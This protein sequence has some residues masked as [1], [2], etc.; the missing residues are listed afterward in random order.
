MKKGFTLLELIIVIIIVGILATIG[1]TQYS[2][3]VEKGRAAEARSIL[4]TLRTAQQSY[5]LENYKYTNTISDLSTKVPESCT[6]THWFE[7]DCS[8]A[9]ADDVICTADRCN[10][11][12]K[13]PN[14]AA[15]ND[16]TLT[17]SASGNWGGS[18]GY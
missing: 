3:T 9:S 8:G 13:N 10:T 11:A 4:G 5:Y 7:Y 18:A 14:A 17:L 16:Y 1:F 6:T 12:G 15:A 2:K